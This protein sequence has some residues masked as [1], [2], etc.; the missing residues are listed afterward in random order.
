[1]NVEVQ[2]NHVYNNIHYESVSLKDELSHPA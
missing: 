2:V 1:M